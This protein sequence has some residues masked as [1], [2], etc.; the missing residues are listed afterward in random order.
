VLSK[1][2]FVVSGKLTTDEEVQAGNVSSGTYGSY[3]KALGG[4]GTLLFMMLGYSIAMG[5]AVFSD[6]WLSIWLGKIVSTSCI[7]R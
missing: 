2:R 1:N 3:V 6:Y 4:V 5:S 7:C